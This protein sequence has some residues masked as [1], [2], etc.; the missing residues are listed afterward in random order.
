MAGIKTA[1]FL[2]QAFIHL[3]EA[4][5]YDP[6]NRNL[7][8]WSEDLSN[9]VWEK[10]NVT[11]VAS[12]RTDPEGTTNADK[13]TADNVA[14]GDQVRQLF[15]KHGNQPGYVTRFTAQA[16]TKFAPNTDIAVALQRASDF[17][18]KIPSSVRIVSGQGTATIDPV[19]KVVDITGLSALA[20]TEVEILWDTDDNTFTDPTFYLLVFPGGA[21][22]NAGAVHVWRSHIEEESPPDGRG[23]RSLGPRKTTDKNGPAG[24]PGQAVIVRA[25]TEGYITRPTDTYPGGGTANNLVFREG[26]KGPPGIRVEAG[27]PSNVGDGSLLNGIAVTSVSDVSLIGPDGMWDKLSRLDWKGRAVRFFRGLPGSAFS[28]FDK[29]HEGIADGTEPDLDETVV[30]FRDP[31]HRLGKLFDLPKFSGHGQCVRG[32]GTGDFVVVGEAPDSWILGDLAIEGRIRLF[33]EPGAVAVLVSYG[34]SGALEPENIAFQVTLDPAVDSLKFEHENGAGVLNTVT[35]PASAIAAADLSDGEWHHWAVSRKKSTKLVTFYWNKKPIGTGTYTNDATGGWN[36]QLRLGAN[37]SGGAT[38]AGDQDETRIWGLVRTDEEIETTAENPIEPGEFLDKGLRA[39][40]R[41]DEGLETRTRDEMTHLVERTMNQ[42]FVSFTGAASS[43]MRIADDGDLD[44]SGDWCFEIRCASAGLEADGIILH[45]A[46]SYGLRTRSADDKFIGK[47]FTSPGGAFQDVVSTNAYVPG[48]DGLV[49]VTIR[50]NAALREVAI[51][52]QGKDKNTFI[53]AAGETIAASASDLFLAATAAA[54]D[55]SRVWTS[56]LRIWDEAPSDATI[57]ARADVILTG[58]EANLKLWVTFDE[59]RA[60]AVIRKMEEAHDTAP[61]YLGTTVFDRQHAVA[62]KKDSATKTDATLINTHGD[63]QGDAHFVGTGE[64]QS[65]LMGKR[66]PYVAGLAHNVPLHL[67]DPLNNVWFG[68]LGP[69]DDYTAIMEGGRKVMIEAITTEDDVYDFELATSPDAA[70]TLRQ[71][72]ATR[73]WTDETANAADSAAHDGDLVILSPTPANGLDDD[74]LYI[75]HANKFCGADIWMFIPIGLGGG[76]VQLELSWQYWSGE[77]WEDLLGLVDGTDGFRIGST[78]PHLSDHGARSGLRTDF[79]KL[80]KNNTFFNHVSKVRWD[81]P[82]TWVKESLADIDTKM[83]LAVANPSD[84]TDRWWIRAASTRFSD[85]YAVTPRCSAV[86]VDELD[87]VYD[88]AT[89][90]IKFNSAP[91]FPPTADVK[92][93]NTGGFKSKPGEITQNVLERFHGYTASQFAAGFSTAVQATVGQYAGLEDVTLANFLRPIMQ[94][95]RSILFGDRDGKLTIKQLDVPEDQTPLDSLKV[96]SDHI[97]S[98]RRIEAAAPASRIDF[99]WRPFFAKLSEND[100]SLLLPPH[101]RKDL[102]SELRWI[103]TAE[104]IED[105]PTRF[106]ESEPQEIRT[107]ISEGLAGGL[108]SETEAAKWVDMIGR[109]RDFTRR[110]FWE[111]VIPLGVVEHSPLVVFDLQTLRYDLW[112]GHSTTGRPLYVLQ[113][114]D[115]GGGATATLLLWG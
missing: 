115:G 91:L 87:A 76:L 2:S 113:Y 79:I 59:I 38:F 78:I 57:L 67:L 6:Q 107:L 88:K 18:L 40:Y 62:N 111:V 96:S 75:G 35:A 60:V 95:V 103:R 27:G 4:D 55:N 102:L 81:P 98:L 51:F 25:A 5:L 33:A 101:V 110:E 42:T 3:M 24:A 32:D 43:H 44:P 47:I 104:G 99:G 39:Y 109:R 71:P 68:A 34:E 94:G 37:A 72:T 7:L 97:L 50:W 17:V 48:Q 9:A 29:T 112:D 100:L 8:L 106:L 82:D 85:H 52:V 84:T 53:A 30:R 20:W 22:Q 26:L 12:G 92:G 16:D 41:M 74:G 46:G 31:L 45:K 21:V 56:E 86:W 1:A 89:G 73:V 63:L 93:D 13:V 77:A 28:T 54:A 19:N 66:K 23:F 90:L 108:S 83:G 114:E 14:A 80:D 69:L 11:R 105:N 65:D 15:A 70:W 64:G 36:G 61:P 49:L 10:I 58:N